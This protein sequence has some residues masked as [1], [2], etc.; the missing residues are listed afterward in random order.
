MQPMRLCILS[1]M[2]FEE[3]CENAQRRKVKKCKQCDYVFSY[4]SALRR[5][6]KKHSGE[7]K[8]MLPVW[9]C[10]L[11]GNPFED[12]SQC[13]Y[14]SSNASSL[15]MHLKSHRGEKSNKCNQCDYGSYLASDL[16]KHLKM[17]SVEKLK[18]LSGFCHSSSGWRY[19]DPASERNRNWWGWRGRGWRW[20]G[21]RWRG[22]RWRGWRWRRAL[23]LFTNG[24][25]I[26]NKKSESW[27]KLCTLGGQPLWPSGLP[28]S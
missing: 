2:Q 20:R 13:D 8:Q 21:Q 5:H 10:I 17:H 26:P 3:T 18:K 22:R 19:S 9:L 14:A 4:A 11:S 12:T 28:N 7:V 27:F 16:R 15:M 23:S 24:L 25:Q 1:G 6:L